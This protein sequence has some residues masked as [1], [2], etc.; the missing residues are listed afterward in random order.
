MR[1]LFFTLFTVIFTCCFTSSAVA[2]ATAGKAVY[3]KVC[4]SCH[5]A[6][7]AGDGPVAAA[8]PADQKPRKFVGEDFKVI[9]DKEQMKELIRKGGATM[10]L[11]PLM[12]AS[13]QLSEEEITQ[14]VEY[15]YALREK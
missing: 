4:A 1:M 11:S 10:G 2:D 12:P 6:T 3:D 8:F 13:P 7:G 5:G 9:K 14:V 15:V